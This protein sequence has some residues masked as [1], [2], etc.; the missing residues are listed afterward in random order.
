MKKKVEFFYDYGSQTSY[1]AWTQLVKLSDQYKF[2]LVFHPILLGGIFK[3][4]GNT[5]PITIEAKG[6]WLFDDIDRY[7]KL[8][9][10]S[11]VKN[12]FFPFNTIKVM[13]GA[14]WA[15][16]NGE[17]TDYNKLL[18]NATWKEGQDISDSSVIEKVFKTSKFNYNDFDSAV[19]TD[20]IKKDLM[21]A[22]N[23]GL[24]RGIFGVP[25][26]F[27]DGAMHFGQ[28]RLDWLKRS[29]ESGE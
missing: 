29:L 22:N 5:A 11:F 3:S 9:G 6:N 25:T 7:A 17:I 15:L 10:V 24:V 27:F 19:Q 28:D 4:T 18:F 21:D 12:S 23:E 2:D 8:Y 1:L 26:I 13:R 14:Q 16:K 20:K